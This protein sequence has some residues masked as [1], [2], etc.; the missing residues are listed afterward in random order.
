M[1]QTNA[2]G[3]DKGMAGHIMLQ[4]SAMQWTDA[5]NSLPPG[6]KVTILE[7]D[8]SK[9]G[10]FTLRMQ[11][12]PGYKIMPHYHPNIEH[13]TIIEGELYMGHG[14]KY[15]ETTA[16]ALPVG[17]FSAIPVKMNH[18]AFTKSKPVV[19]QLHGVGP[20][21]IIYLDPANDLRKAKKGK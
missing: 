6:A 20:W 16:T 8:P 15:D 3:K 1:A 5:P 9:A 13:V 7:G 19:L 12:P 17:S 4:P 2:P 10:P 11:A 14:D 18:Y 21:D